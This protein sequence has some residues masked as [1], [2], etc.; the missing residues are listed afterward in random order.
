M[1]LTSRHR[2]IVSH[3]KTRVRSPHF[4]APSV[5]CNTSVHLQVH[6]VQQGVRL[7][8]ST[9]VHG[10]QQR[11]HLQ[12]HFAQQKLKNGNPHLQVRGGGRVHFVRTT[13][14]LFLLML[15]VNKLARDAGVILLHM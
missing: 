7:T 13:M 11:V 14:R 5:N 8:L 12:V 10:A 3:E 4:D 6:F 2:R 1:K 9:I 15:G